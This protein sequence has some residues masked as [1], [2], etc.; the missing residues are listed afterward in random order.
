M[1]LN[2]SLKAQKPKRQSTSN[3][4]RPL[5]ERRPEILE[6]LIS[7]TCLLVSVEKGEECRRRTLLEDNPTSG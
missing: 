6:L 1:R 5:S 2:P 4:E 3:D 7:R